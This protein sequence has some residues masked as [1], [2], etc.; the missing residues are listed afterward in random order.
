M[1]PFALFCLHD[2]ALFSK[3]HS[4]RAYPCENTGGSAG[5]G[6]F[7]YGIELWPTICCLPPCRAFFERL[8]SFLR[9]GF[10]TLAV[11][12]FFMFF[13]LFLAACFLFV[14]HWGTEFRL[15]RAGYSGNAAKRKA[16]YGVAAANAS[17]GF[18]VF[19]FAVFST[20]V[21]ILAG[22]FNPCAV[23]GIVDL[24]VGVCPSIF[25]VGVFFS[26]VHGARQPGFPWLVFG[27]RHDG[28][29]LDDSFFK[30]FS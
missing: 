22:R 28:S 13:L 7:A 30:A 6:C 9:F 24:G 26:G 23:A 14:G 12:G 25:F 18:S 5:F 11:V 10:A 19:F 27:S 17:L 29:L 15:V 21:S 1:W 2:A 3:N 16:L 20:H 8:V 4:F